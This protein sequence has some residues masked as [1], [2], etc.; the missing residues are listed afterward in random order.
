M[1]YLV[2]LLAIGFLNLLM[3]SP[4]ATAQEKKYADILQSEAARQGTTTCAAGITSCHGKVIPKVVNGK[5]AKVGMFPWVVS[6][7]SSKADS[8]LGHQCGGTLISDHFVLSAAHCFLDTALPVDFTVQMGTV[9]L[10]KYV[11]QPTISRILFHKN[12]DRSTNEADIALL[13]LSSPVVENDRVRSIS[14]Q[15][16]DNFASGGH[17]AGAPRLRYNLSGFGYFR[18]REFPAALQ[19]S[20]DIP[21]L[22][23]SECRQLKVWSETIFGEAIKSDMICAGDTTNV[24]ASDACKGDSGGGLISLEPVPQVVGIVSRGA[25]PDG[26]LDCTDQALRV[27]VYTKVSNYASQIGACTSGS[28]ECDFV[29]PGQQ[30]A[31]LQN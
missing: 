3:C 21:S 28:A 11:G 7:G 18:D 25:L 30:R 12:F 31:T 26:S 6:V 14:L 13:E 16:P 5:D 17:E 1:R 10:D 23:T 8:F 2:Q 4:S 19:Y 22:T 24:G 20:D 29:S 27:G 9:N 15:T